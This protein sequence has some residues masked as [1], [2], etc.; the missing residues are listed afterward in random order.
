[1]GFN[2]IPLALHKIVCNTVTEV[3]VGSNAAFK[4]C[5]L[6]PP[7]L[8]WI[9]R[10]PLRVALFFPVVHLEGESFVQESWQGFRQPEKWLI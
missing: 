9:L 3:N 2:K 7:P 8:V 6:H 5:L 4:V 1:L 10:D